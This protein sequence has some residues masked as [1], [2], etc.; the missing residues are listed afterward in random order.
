M[1]V[2]FH[3]HPRVLVTPGDAPLLLTTI[4]EKERFIP[5]FFDGTVLVL[6][7]DERL[8]NLKPVDFVKDILVDRIG[9]GKLI[10]GYDHAIG[11]N[12][13]G[14][15]AQLR[16]LGQK[17]G[18]DIEVCPP[19]LMDGAAVSS[20]RIRRCLLQERFGEAVRLLGHEYAICGPIE[21][22]IGLG[23]KLGYPTANVGYNQRKLLPPA[24]VY[25]CCAEI[26]GDCH[27]GV[28]F[29]GHNHFNPE[30]RVSVE[31]HLFDFD[32]DIYNRVITVYPLHYIRKNRR[33]QSP[34][35][36]VRQIRKDEQKALQ[37]L[38]KEKADGSDKGAKGSDRCRQSS[39]R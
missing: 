20:S 31:A 12:R 13:S 6:D 30:K 32:E 18:Y 34:E 15:I 36:L 11:K 1:L 25:T 26:N 2:T 17:F 14:S 37:I 19:V 39:S 3:P 23:K 16:E 33:F 8:M 24:G 35:A 27:Q 28:M 38:Q 22:G 21:K 7:F 5:D 29:I 10:V 4:E 9:T